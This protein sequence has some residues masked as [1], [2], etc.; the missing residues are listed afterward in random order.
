[1]TDRLYIQPGV[2]MKFNKG[3]G[4]NSINPGTPR[5]SASLNVGSRSYINGFDQNN[6]YSPP[7]RPDSSK[8]RLPIRPCYSR[9]STTTSA[10]T[11]LVP[12]PST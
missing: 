12:D 4:L 10:T 1:M 9:R 8:S 3:S 6:D 5:G 11:T 7:T 2:M